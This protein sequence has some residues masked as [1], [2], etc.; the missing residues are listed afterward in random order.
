[1]I[2][3]TAVAVLL[4]GGGLMLPMNGL[5]EDLGDLLNAPDA[6]DGKSVKITGIAGEP[7]Y[8]ESRGKPFTVFDLSDGRGRSL[9]IFSWGRLQVHRGE[10]LVVEGT[11]IKSKQVGEH[12]FQSEIEATDVHPIADSH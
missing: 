5:A 2:I 9:R 10:R 1:L 6:F 7:R 8:N 4:I 3:R 11:F 12:A